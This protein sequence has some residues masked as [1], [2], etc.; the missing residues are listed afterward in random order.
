MDVWL[1]VI[2]LINLQNIGMNNIPWTYHLPAAGRYTKFFPL[3]ERIPISF[4]NNINDDGPFSIAVALLPLN[5]F[6]QMFSDRACYF[7]YTIHPWSLLLILL[8]S[9]L[10]IQVLKI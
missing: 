9:Y 1:F 8:L 10:V 4:A 2:F 3:Y 7:I 6:L 5:D